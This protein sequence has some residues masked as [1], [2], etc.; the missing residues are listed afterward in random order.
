MSLVRFLAVRLSLLL[1][2]LILVSMIIFAAVHILPGD[3]ARMMLGPFADAQAVT[4]LNA[5]LGTDRPMLVQYGEWIYSA[6]HGDFGLSLSM[7]SPVASQVADAVR[8]SVGLAAIALLLVVPTGVGAGI[9]AGLNRGTWLDRAIILIGVSL[10]I[11]PDF[12][13]A[14][15]FIIVFALWLNWFPLSGPQAG[16]GLW[17]SVYHLILPAIPLVLNL[18]GYIARLT[19]TGVIEAKEADYTRTAVLKGLPRSTVLLHHILRNALIPTVAVLATQSGYLLGGLLVIE[20]LFNIP[21]LGNLILSAA[22]ARDVPL[23]EGGVLVMAAIFGVCAAA[24]DLLQA[25]LD[26]RLRQRRAF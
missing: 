5:K 11:V 23:L 3:V 10:S 19:R 9:V 22:K 8:H 13:S 1:V 18:F 21:G 15:I 17:E 20:A 4:T 24:G 14:L 7:R 16:A 25:F 6:L 26:P 12:V 2:T